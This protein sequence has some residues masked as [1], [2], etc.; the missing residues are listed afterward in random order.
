M[1]EKFYVI[2]Y[3]EWVPVKDRLHDRTLGKWHNREDAARKLD[4][5]PEGVQQMLQIEERSE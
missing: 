5:F 4:T 2:R 3:Q 1:T